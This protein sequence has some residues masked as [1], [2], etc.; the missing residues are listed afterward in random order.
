MGLATDIERRMVEAG[1]RWGLEFKR[2]NR[3]EASASACPF[4][5]L[6]DHDGFLIFSDG[7]YWCRQCGKRGWLDEG[8]AEPLTREKLL[9]LRIQAL[10]RKQR[11]H[12]RRLSALEQMA[13]CTDHLRYHESLTDQA[14]AYWLDEG[15]TEESIERYLLGY[16]QN[17]P[18]YPESASYT[19]PVING[20]KLENIRHR[21]KK[22]DG[23]GKYRPHMAGLGNSLFNADLLEG[24][25]RIVVTEGEKK[26]IILTQHGF[27]AVGICGKRAFKRE[28]LERF[29]PLEVVYVALDPDATESAKRLA[30][31][32]EG[33]GRVV[34]LPCKPDDMIVKY[35]ASSD[36]MESF[37]RLSRPIGG[38]Y[39]SRH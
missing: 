39:D 23:G 16:C 25:Q 19:I 33:R 12:E 10:E 14:L 27:P 21:L 9:E 3:N 32:F 31:M 29:A 26:S 7:G 8:S 15:M 22:P 37:L 36:D 35:G 2:K 6:V 34:D 38:G 20:G 18:T 4:C 17:C 24:A 28:W 13:K 11:E 5:N 1:N 30:G